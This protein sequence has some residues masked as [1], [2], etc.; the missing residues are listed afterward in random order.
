[1]ALYDICRPAIINIP[2]NGYLT[3]AILTTSEAIARHCRASQ[4]VVNVSID[5]IGEKHDAIRNLAGSYAKC[6][7]TFSGLKQIGAPNLSVGIHSV[8]SKFNVKRIPEIYETIRQL[9]PDSYITEIAE[10]R[11]ELGTVGSGITPSYEDYATAVDFLSRQLVRETFNRV[12][13]MARAFRIEYYD[14]VKRIL[15]EKRQVIPCY[16][17]VASAHIAPD[18][19]VWMCC[20]QA[21]PVGNLRDCNYDFREI[22]FSDKAK[23][24]R[25]KIKTGQCHCPLANASYT[26]ILQH[27]GSLFRVASNITKK[28]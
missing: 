21:E 11:V 8:I 24:M 10:E 26:N 4:L 13:S 5:E 20:V 16:A 1:M 7:A 12:G 18:G 6:L 25:R 2:T 9:H 3:Q 28:G 15:R 22:W 23:K 14:L 27:P 19:D 17:G